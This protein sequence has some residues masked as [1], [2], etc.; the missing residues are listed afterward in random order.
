MQA[1]DEIHPFSETAKCRN[2]NVRNRVQGN[3]PKVMK[4]T[5]VLR[6]QSGK[7][8]KKEKNA[9]LYFEGMFVF[10]ASGGVQCFDE[11]CLALCYRAVH[12]VRCL[13]H[14]VSR[15]KGMLKNG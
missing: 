10:V 13:F 6:N 8:Y 3:V 4:S 14:G 9:S 5:C 2:I 11:I 15:I 7:T 12:T 1:N